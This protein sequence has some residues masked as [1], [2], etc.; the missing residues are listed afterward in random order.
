MKVKSM[1]VAVALAVTAPLFAQ[2]SQEKIESRL[3][4]LERLKITGYLQAQ[5]VDDERSRD[6]LA[7]SGTRNLDQ[8]SVRRG[9]V[10]FIY[11]ATPTSKLVLQPDISSSSVTLKDGYIELTE[12][13]TTW[14]HTLTA[15][16]FLWP[17]G[18]ELP[19]TCSRSATSSASEGR[20]ERTIAA[21]CR[22]AGSPPSTSERTRFT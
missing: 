16:Q 10:K 19:T 13:W 12:P 15:G 17:F 8:F 5:F 14:K 3:A 22:A 7:G 18:F 1:M 21:Q 20:N 6:E 4:F 2:E 11:Q 9:R